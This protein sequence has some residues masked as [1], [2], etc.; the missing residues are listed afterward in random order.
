MDTIDHMQNEM[1]FFYHC[2]KFEYNHDFEIFFWKSD[3]SLLVFAV[4][5]FGVK[6]FTIYKKSLTYSTMPS[7]STVILSLFNSSPFFNKYSYSFFTVEISYSCRGI[8]F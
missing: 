7:L 3:D 4:F 5:L 1:D 6:N 8:Y 2:K